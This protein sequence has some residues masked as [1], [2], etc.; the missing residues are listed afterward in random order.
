MNLVR[1]NFETQNT[2]SQCRY[3][4]YPAHRVLAAFPFFNEEDKLRQM[5]TPTSLATAL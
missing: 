2:L 5:A 4:L 3:T 1:D